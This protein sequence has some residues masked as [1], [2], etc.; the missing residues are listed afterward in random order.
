[1]TASFLY[2]TGYIEQ[3]YTVLERWAKNRIDLGRGWFWVALFR[4]WPGF[5]RFHDLAV[6]QMEDFIGE[7]VDQIVMGSQ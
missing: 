3:V 7:L 6:C 4:G 1:M 5:G 2:V